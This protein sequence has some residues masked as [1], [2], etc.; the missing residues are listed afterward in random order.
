MDVIW[1]QLHSVFR[2][3]HN[4]TWK[5]SSCGRACSPM[6]FVDVVEEDMQKVGLTEEDTRDR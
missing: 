5:L 4:I 2:I 6:E 3:D 1:P